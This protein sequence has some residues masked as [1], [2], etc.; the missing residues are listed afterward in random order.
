MRTVRL[1]ENIDVA[2]ECIVAIPL[3]IF[4]D[5][6]PD[7]DWVRGKE[8]GNRNVRC[9]AIDVILASRSPHGFMDIRK[10]FPRHYLKKQPFLRKDGA[11][12]CTKI[13][14]LVPANRAFDFSAPRDVNQRDVT[15][16][17]PI[18]D[19][20]SFFGCLS[21]AFR[22]CTAIGKAVAFCAVHCASF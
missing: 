8:F 6:R 22:A 14:C 4:V 18:N 19:M 5:L 1:N 13:L 10:G 16:A 12:I 7:L 15:A 2:I 21:A 20:R 9:L 17:A 11:H 3:G